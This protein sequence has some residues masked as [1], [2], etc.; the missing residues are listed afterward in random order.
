MYDK[1]GELISDALERGALQHNDES[2]PTSYDVPQKDALQQHNENELTNNTTVS[3]AA[4]NATWQSDSKCD[5]STQDDKKRNCDMHDGN[6]HNAAAKFYRAFS[7]KKRQGEIVRGSNSVKKLVAV[8]KRI[9]AAYDVLGIAAS[10]SEKE[11]HSAYREKL[12]LF[13]PDSNSKNETVQHVA[14]KKTEE[15]I[16]AYTAI[17]AWRQG[18][19]R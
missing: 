15:V 9:T 11:L 3:D 10:A 1:L 12:K 5:I 13:H 6:L 19:S 18:H 8:P 4:N 16:A 14:Q 7:Q 2:V 17:T